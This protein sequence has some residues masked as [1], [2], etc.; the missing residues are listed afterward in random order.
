[1]I[2][3]VGLSIYPGVAGPA[4]GIG[5]RLGFLAIVSGS[6]VKSRASGRHH[7]SS[8]QFP[9]VAGIDGVG[10]LDDGSRVYFVLPRA[11]Y[12]GMAEQTVV[13]TFTSGS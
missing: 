3:V 1:V 4:P 9:F 10:R 8:G 6:V 12:G 11:P 2:G 13:P 5:L 7:S